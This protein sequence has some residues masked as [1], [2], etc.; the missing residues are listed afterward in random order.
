M[1][2][3]RGF[4]WVGDMVVS[5]DGNP[6]LGL[7]HDGS[8]EAYEYILSGGSTE[9]ISYAFYT[10]VRLHGPSGSMVF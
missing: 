2:K 6:V 10:A 7:D 4:G 9:T 3:R 5:I 1:K 8:D